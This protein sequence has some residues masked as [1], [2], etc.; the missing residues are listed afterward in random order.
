MPKETKKQDGKE[1]HNTLKHKAPRC[2]NH[3]ATQ[4]KNNAETTALERSVA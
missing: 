2:I 3:N 1:Q 4:N